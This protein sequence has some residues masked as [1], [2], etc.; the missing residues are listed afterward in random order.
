MQMHA[1]RL[2]RAAALTPWVT[3]PWVTCAPL[4]IPC[5]S[6]CPLPLDPSPF[7]LTCCETRRYIS[8]P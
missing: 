4:P 3:A 7:P 2:A 8:C 6:Y 1:A 5:P